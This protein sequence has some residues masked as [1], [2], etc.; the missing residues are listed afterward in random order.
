M[1]N[2]ATV[3]LLID[4][5]AAAALMGISRAH[6][7]RLR[8]AGQFPEAIR[9]GR[10]LRFDRNELVAWAEARCPDLATWKAMCAAGR[11][12]HRDVS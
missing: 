12:R 8:A 2:D 7:H 1:T 9:L 4:D 10:A 11:R 5:C 6:L 3:P